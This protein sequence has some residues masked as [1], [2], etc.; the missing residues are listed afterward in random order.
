[1]VD[2]LVFELSK[3]NTPAIRSRV[4]AHLLNIDD[5]LAGDVAKGLGLK[6][7]PKPAKPA[8]PTQMDIEPSPALSILKNLKNTFKGRKLG[9]LVTDGVDAGL[10]SALKK[11]LEG[12]GADMDII[13]PT[14]GGVTATDGSTVEGDEKLGGGPSVLYDAVAILPSEDGI[15]DLMSEP[16]ARDFVADAFAH[17]KFVLFTEPARQLF[18]KAGLPDDLDDGFMPFGKKAD[19]KS[20]VDSCAKLRFWDREGA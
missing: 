10:L 14:V 20:F 9:V 2:A 7:M 13:A 4:V 1:M 5:A 12:A 6:E 8:K 16:A 11:A 17:Y 3:V 15:G 19:A 18:Q